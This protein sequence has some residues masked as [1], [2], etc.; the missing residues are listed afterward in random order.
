MSAAALPDKFIILRRMIYDD[1]PAVMAIEQVSFSNPWQESTFRGEIQNRPFSYPYVIVHAV[2][3]KVIG[4]II[5]WQIKDEAQ[6]NNIAVLPDYRH[7]G[8]GEATLRQVIEEVAARG[9]T[10]IS[11]EV[12]TS[13]LPALFLYRKLGFLTLGVRKNYYSHPVEDAFVMGLNLLS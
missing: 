11:L 1:L 8:A 2:E 10:F 6:I 12:R 9:A 5:Y 13:N 7:I 4:Y 3:K